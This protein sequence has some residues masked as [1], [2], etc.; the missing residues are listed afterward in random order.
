MFSNVRI[1]C[2]KYR[3]TYFTQI[4]WPKIKTGPALDFC[5]S[6]KIL[7]FEKPGS[8]SKYLMFSFLHSSKRP[9]QLMGIGRRREIIAHKRQFFCGAIQNT[10][11]VGHS[12]PCKTK[13][14]TGG[15]GGWWF[16]DENILF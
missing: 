11:I 16:D 10:S 14:R 7:L 8:E 6:E 4:D 1:F 13:N 2:I 5:S 3:K 12:T 9:P 15:K